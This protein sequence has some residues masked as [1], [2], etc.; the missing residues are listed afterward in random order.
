MV[1]SISF[2]VGLVVTLVLA[3]VGGPSA[4]AQVTGVIVANPGNQSTAWDQDVNLQLHA[5][6]G[7]QP[8]HWSASGLM[9]GAHLDPSTGLIS[10]GADGP[11]NATYTVTISAVDAVGNPGGTTFQWRVFPRLRHLLNHRAAQ[12]AA[13][14]RCR[15]R[16]RPASRTRETALG[17]TGAR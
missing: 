11:R 16:P 15:R 4:S 13:G 2:I 6:G 9:L 1:R 5:S 3:V 14:A 17:R 10:G 12:T 8:Y 7:T